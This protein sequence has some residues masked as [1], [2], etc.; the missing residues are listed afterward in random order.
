M[1]LKPRLKLRTAMYR[2]KGAQKMRAIALAAARSVVNKKAEKKQKKVESVGTIPLTGIDTNM[3]SIS[4]G[5]GETQRIGNKFTATGFYHKLVAT[6]NYSNTQHEMVRVIAYIPKNVNDS[7]S[8]EAT[9]PSVNDEIDY[10]KY[11]V[12]YD[13]KVCL[14]QYRP[15]HTFVISRKW[16]KKGL[17]VE[18]STG[19]AADIV[20][21]KLQI[22]YVSDQPTNE[23]RFQHLGQLWF[24]DM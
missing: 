21:N 16:N 2:Q 10:N 20:K 22:Y 7:L 14:N 24:T 19:S 5:T 18:Y 6:H 23:P 8:T 3:C 1:A 13:R 4:A 12:L 17:P 9:P 11:T 15:C